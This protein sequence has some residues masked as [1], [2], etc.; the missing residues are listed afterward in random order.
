MPSNAFTSS[1]QMVQCSEGNDPQRGMI[2]Q[3]DRLLSLH[4]P[5]FDL[6]MRELEC[7]ALLSEMPT[8]IIDEFTKGGTLEFFQVQ[9]LLN[10]T[11]NMR[12]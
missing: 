4:V 8:L 5:L 3:S 7:L 12:L 11:I 10:F 6:G 9:L 1:T 2:L